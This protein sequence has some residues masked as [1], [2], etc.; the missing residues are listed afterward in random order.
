MISDRLRD[1]VE[2]AFSIQSKA[3]LSKV[4]FFKK[5]SVIIDS[6]ESDKVVLDFEDGVK[7]ELSFKLVNVSNVL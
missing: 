7:F 3:I 1:K 2:T 5:C 6:V 4:D